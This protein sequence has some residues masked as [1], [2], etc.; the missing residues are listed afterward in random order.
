MIIDV[1]QVER[2]ILAQ[3]SKR[4]KARINSLAVTYNNE[5]YIDKYDRKVYGEIC[6]NFD[7]N[8]LHHGSTWY[9]YHKPPTLKDIRKC[10]RAFTKDVRRALIQEEKYLEKKCI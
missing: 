2:N 3:I 1:S 6:V 7:T 10:L 5:Y 4:H 9:F 8:L